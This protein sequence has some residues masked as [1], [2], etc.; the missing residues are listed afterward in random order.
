MTRSTTRGTRW[1]IPTSTFRADQT[2]YTG[3]NQ[4]INR[5][6][7]LVLRAGTG[8]NITRQLLLLA[9]TRRRSPGRRVPLEHRQLQQEGHALGRP[10]DQEP[11][12][13]VGPTIQGMEELIAR[14]PS[15]RWDDTTN[16]VVDSAF[17]AAKPARVPD[18]CCTTRPSTTPGS[19]W[20]ELPILKVANWIGFF[21]ESSPGQRIIGR[22]IPI[23]RD[24]GRLA[25]A[26]RPEPYEQSGS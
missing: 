22:I 19:G 8:T 12:N 24:Q 26:A 13:K 20:A 16:R 2:G 21:V 10:A 11:G 14:D 5:G 25:R 15:A 1:Q 4:E 6:Q 3:Y 23:A 17:P 18:S 9:G 7:H